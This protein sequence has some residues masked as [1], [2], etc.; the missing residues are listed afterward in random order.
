M[1]RGH[2]ICSRLGIHDVVGAARCR[3]RGRLLQVTEVLGGVWQLDLQENAA[4]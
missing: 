3:R 2:E 4:R 1:G